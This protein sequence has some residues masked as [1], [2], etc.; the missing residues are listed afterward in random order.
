MIPLYRKIK[1]YKI[2]GKM[3]QY[4]AIPVGYHFK[5]NTLLESSFEGV[6]NAQRNGLSPFF[7]VQNLAV[8]GCK[9]NFSPPYL[10]PLILYLD[11][12]HV[13]LQLLNIVI[14]VVQ[15][16]H[17]VQQLLLVVHV[18][19]LEAPLVLKLVEVDLNLAQSLSKQIIILHL[20]CLDLRFGR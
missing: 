2:L 9:L 12:F 11:L 13:I 18:R 16:G 19:H 6:L 4:E 8:V 14:Q 10:P 3:I 7:V 20:L 17:Y 1:I 15:T 5:S